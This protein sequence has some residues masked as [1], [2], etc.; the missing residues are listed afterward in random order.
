MSISPILPENIETFT[1]ETS[2][3]KTFIS[4]SSGTTGS[5]YVFARRSHTEKEVYPLSLYSLSAFKDQDLSGFLKTAKMNAMSMSFN[6]SDIEAYMTALNQQQMS[7]RKLQTVDVVRF[8]PGFGTSQNMF[9]KGTLLNTIFPY[10]RHIYP[11]AQYAFNNYHSLNFISSSLFPSESVLL[12]PQNTTL[13]GNII[14]SGD[15]LVSSAFSFDFWIK[16][17]NTTDSDAFSYKPGTIMSV[18]G[19]YAI[20]LVSGSSKDANGNPDKFRILFQLSGAANTPP[21]LINS[22]SLQAMSYMTDDNSLFKNTWHH[23]T[24]RWGTKDYNLGSGSILIDG[25]NRCNFVVTESALTFK[26]VA[27]SDGPSVVSV[28]NFYE[29]TNTGVNSLS[30]FFAADTATREG[31]TQINANTS[32]DYPTNWNFTHPLNAE[33]HDLKLY[34]KF[35]TNDEITALR[36]SGPTTLDNIIFYVP[37]FFTAES[38]V[39]QM[40]NGTGGVFVTPFQTKTGTTRTPFSAELA[41]EMGGHYINLENFTR[42]FVRNRYPRL[43]G[44]S[45]SVVAAPASFPQTVNTILYST[46]SIRRR[47]LVVLPCDNGDFFPNFKFLNDKDKSY[48]HN[49]LNHEDL[50]LVSLREIYPTSSIYKGMQLGASGSIANSLIGPDPEKPSSFGNS[51]GS[52]PTILQRTRDNTSNQ[53]V[54]FDCSSLFYGQNIEP[55]S[56]MIYDSSLSGSNK[57]PMILKDDEYGNV[58][59][60]DATGSLATW[61]SVGNVFYNEGIVILKHPSLFFFG[62][63]QFS[64]SFK[65]KQNIHTLT[66]DCIARSGQVTSSSNPSYIPCSASAN[67]NESDQKYVWITDVL[68]HDDNMN[69]VMRTKLAQHFL[70]KTGDRVLFKSTMD[71]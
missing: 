65:G 41:F 16:P 19:C 55:G 26:T 1:L 56:L 27:G 69:V 10:Y 42:E 60:A 63:N 12:Y 30:R 38:P 50:S 35:L 54:F 22:S 3:S 7:L 23:V 62:E 33:I 43:I 46:A 47:S 32:I 36:I 44:L 13:S 5:A 51:S 59:R 58:Y 37:P 8:T 4:S 61:N 2:P 39:R 29:G 48:F 68:I 64:I 31:L 34:N 70:K 18:S 21:Y 25:N 28:G 6:R 71:F 45:G 17:K 14:T 49:D 9:R 15:Y 24:I 40:V 66:I 67:V 52:V 11:S 20:S 57:N 53:V